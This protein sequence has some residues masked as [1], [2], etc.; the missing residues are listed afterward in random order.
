M[1]HQ[2]VLLDLSKHQINQ[3][4]SS[5]GALLTTVRRAKRENAGLGEVPQEVR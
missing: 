3:L 1:T 2:Q 4:H 5:D